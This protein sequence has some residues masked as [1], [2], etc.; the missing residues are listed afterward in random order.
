VGGRPPVAAA[1]GAEVKRGFREL[2]TEDDARGKGCPGAQRVGTFM[3]N[4][5]GTNGNDTRIGA[6]AA[7][8][9]RL[10]AGN[11][12]GYGRAGNDTIYGGLGLD[13]LYG[14][15]GNDRLFGEDG[16]DTLR[17]GGGN[18]LLD[19]GAGVDTAAFDADTGSVTVNLTTGSARHG[20]GFL[21]TL[22][23]IENVIGGGFADLIIGDNNANRLEG[24]GGNDQMFGLGGNDVILG[25]DGDDFAQGDDGSD[26]LS[27]EGG[28]DVLA[29]G[30]DNDIISGGDG[31]DNDLGFLNG[32]VGLEGGAGNDQISGGAGNDTLA[33]GSDSDRLSGDDGDD[34]LEGGDGNDV[35]NGGTGVD[36]LFGGSGDDDLF[37]DGSG[38]FLDGGAGSD[39]MRGS[40]NVSAFQ[41]TFTYDASGAADDQGDDIIVDFR[42]GTDKVRFDAEG[43]TSF[44]E[45]DTNG[46]LKLDNLDDDVTV[47]FITVDGVRARSTVIDISNFEG[48]ETTTETLTFFNNVDIN[49]NDFIII[50]DDPEPPVLGPLD[51]A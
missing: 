13:T 19:G 28:S 6:G 26:E 10:L 42:D 30:A 36:N 18:D 39:I 31:D 16:D 38:D 43:L 47:R 48:D 50:N 49:E 15:Q 35:L 5:N 32:G 9:I 24:R 7:D 46:N 3:A 4:I 21:D 23:S 33:G 12:I 29:G 22:N 14:E 37:G 27:G 8:T 45:L 2:E 40:Q 20:A 17:G 25:G 41:D 1:A 11:D 34:L 51:I 44:S